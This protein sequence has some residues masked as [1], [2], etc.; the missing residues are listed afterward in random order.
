[1]GRSLARLLRERIFEPL[2]LTATTYTPGRRVLDDAQMH[3]YDITGDEPRDVSLY[4][5]G[6]PWADG[7]I[8]SNARDLAVFFGALLRGQLVPPKLVTKMRTI[9]RNSHGEGLGLYRL[10]SPCGR[11]F[12]GHTGGTPG[13]LTFAAGTLD[14]SRMFV[15]AVNGID[16]TAMETVVGPYLDDLLCA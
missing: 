9:V 7:A 3:G 10:G 16:P 1:L 6:G 14:G 12:Y 15:F 11:W 5:L 4:G 2:G 8:V 13:Y